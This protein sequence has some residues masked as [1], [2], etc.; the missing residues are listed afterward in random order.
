MKAF[1][2]CLLAGLYCI[3]AYNANGQCTSGLQYSYVN[4]A[5]PQAAPNDGCITLTPDA[6]SKRG[7]AWDVN[8][9]IDFTAD[10]SYD[11]KINLGSNAGGADGMCFVIQNDPAGRCA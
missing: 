10:F 7:C 1:L 5:V 2:G 11:F 8:S 6:T 3:I 9:T 4:D